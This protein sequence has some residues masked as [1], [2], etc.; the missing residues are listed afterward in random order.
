MASGRSEVPT[1]LRGSRPPAEE[2][3][4]A[5]L[6]TASR[7]I[8][9]AVVRSLAAAS[10]AVS[11]PQLR[12]LVMLAGGNRMN[13]SAVAEGLGVNASNASRTCGR[14]VNLGLVDRQTDPHDRRHVSLALSRSGQRLVADVM[15]HRE[16]LLAEVVSAMPAADQDLL[17]EALTAFIAAAEGIPAL[18]P[19]AGAE[20]DLAHW[21]A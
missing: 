19:P 4:L 15:R 1:S 2:P 21:S 16:Q 13:L 8:I 11:V 18:R 17:N 6:M 9:A 7:T 10:E 14:L 5:P 20:G 3:D 12:V